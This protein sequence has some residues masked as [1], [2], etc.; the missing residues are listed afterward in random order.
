MKAN[1]LRGVLLAAVI[2]LVYCIVFAAVWFLIGFI[3]DLVTQ[4]GFFRGMLSGR[5]SVLLLIATLPAT[6]CAYF[7]STIFM[8]IKMKNEFTRGLAFRIAGAF[9]FLGTIALLI[10]NICLKWALIPFSPCLIG[11]I[12]VFFHG[13]WIADDAK[14]ELAEI[15]EEQEIPESVHQ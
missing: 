7:S 8:K 14:N 5:L 13:K 2:I 11:S 3:T 9:L 12:I 6:L 1:A 10:V 4:D 15:N